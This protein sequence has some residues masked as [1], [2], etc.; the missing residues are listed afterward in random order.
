MA[1][2]TGNGFTLYYNTDVGNRS[3]QSINNKIIDSVAEFPTFAITSQTNNIE[4]YDSNYT[5]VLLGEIGV[6]TIDLKVNYIPDNA[7]H[8]FLDQ[9]A[10][11]NEEFQLVL[12]Y[13]KTDSDVLYAILNGVISSASVAGGKDEVL[14][15]TYGF[16]PTVLV[17][18][19][20]MIAALNPLYEGDYGVGSNGDTVPSYTGTTGNAFVKVPASQEGNPIGA[21]MLGISLVDTGSVA[22]IAVSKSGALSI[23]AKNAST[24]WTRIY[25]ATQ[26]DSRYVPLTRTVNGK[27][28]SANISLTKTDIG[29]SNVT[30]DAQLKIESNLGDLNNVATARTNLSVYSKDETDAAYVPQTRTVNGKALSG[31]ISITKTDVGLSNVTNDS[32][33]K[34]ASNLGDLANVTTA[35]TNL[36]LGTAAV[37]NVGT[38]GAVVPLLSTA[39]TWSGVQTFSNTITGSISGTASNVTG[40]VAIANGGTGAT[41]A[42]AARSN[43]GLGTSS[44]VN[45]G[46]SGAVVPLLSTA[47][48]WSG[49]QTFS[50]TISGSISGTASNVTGVVSIANGGTGANTTG[51]ARANLGAVNI[52]GDTMNGALRVPTNN[53]LITGDFTNSDSS[54]SYAAIS[55]ES[56]FAMLWRK[57]NSG[58]ANQFIGIHPGR[59]LIY[60]QATDSTG[61]YAD[62]TVYHDGNLP[63]IASQGGVPFQRLGNVDINTLTGAQAGNYVQSANLNATLANNYPEQ[64]AGSLIVLQNAA[65]NNAGCIQIY[66]PF[67]N[68]N[69]WTR[70]LQYSS[71]TAYIWTTWTRIAWHEYSTMLN[72]IGLGTTSSPTF[73]VLNLTR[74]D[75]TSNGEAIRLISPTG[76]AA[77]IMGYTANTG[78]AADRRWYLGNGGSDTS[79]TLYNSVNANNIVLHNGGGIS[80]VARSASTGGN[81][82]V[83]SF[84]PNGTIVGPQGTVTQTA[85]DIK[86]KS[87]VLPAQEGA[88]DRIKSIGCVEFTWDS[89]G[90]RDR[91]FIAQQI[92]DIDEL[93]TFKPEGCDYLNYSATALLSDTFGAIQE[94]SIENDKL[95]KQIDELKDL[96][97]SLINKE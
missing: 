75:V 76:S 15:K 41:T 25:T 66:Y 80:L 30:N 40:T 43:L 22:S 2:F 12:V 53:G 91:G 3:P 52:S 49:V 47:N 96:V 18:R 97:Q 65:N 48:T 89:D 24:A 77:Y 46:T 81:T 9:M 16:T 78:A 51:G 4:T 55:A 36:G 86:L 87:G 5:S 8:M 11:T 88:L 21:D 34:I 59:N 82:V 44:T 29:L 10:E 94:L 50:N 26:M 62:R 54:L 23:F 95:Q 32:Q 58:A 61:G 35:R 73:N 83:S 33:L 90:R 1:I 19:A 69:I 39:N 45:V 63:S 17:Q 67:A 38:S 93:Y 42:A 64:I 72:E 28:L 20:T 13:E 70:R 79:V 57:D 56:G 14:T 71:G 27:A 68:G 31:D 74:L 6:G 60:R 7:S 84:N 85:S 92:A 37:S